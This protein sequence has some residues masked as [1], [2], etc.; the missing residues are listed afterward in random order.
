MRLLLDTSVVLWCL[1]GSPRLGP[2]ARRVIAA[3]DSEVWVSAASAW[4]IAIKAA[5]GRPVYRQSPEKWLPAQLERS[6]FQPLMI[7]M[8]HALAV[9]TL[10]LHHGDPFDRMIIAQGL[11]ERLKVVTA[12]DKF[13][14]YGTDLIDATA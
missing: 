11:L 8:E 2:K 10:P 3:A 9:A 14:A 13:D 1:S 6:R 12:D 5:A 4:E 7:T